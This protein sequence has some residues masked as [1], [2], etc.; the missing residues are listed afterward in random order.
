M[1]GKSIKR[2]LAISLISISM[3]AIGGCAASEPAKGS[4]TAST[5]ATTS[6][7]NNST[8]VL[9][10]EKPPTDHDVSPVEPTKVFD[11]LYYLGS[12]NVGAWV[13]NTSEGIILID[14]MNN[15]EDAENIIVPGIKKLG[16]DPANI[17]YVLVT[18]GHGD[19]YGGAKYIQD[20]FGATVLMSSIDWDFMVKNYK[21]SIAAKAEAEA[22]GKDTSK[23]R[24][25][26]AIPTS[27]TNITDDEKLTLGDTTITV[28]Y[29]P[30]HTPGCVSLIIPVTDN[31]K[32]HT[33]SIWGG[34]GLP[35][36]LEDNK[37]YESSIDYF[38]KFTDAAQVD[39]EISAHPF[40]DNAVE[41]MD[42]LGKRK[43]GDQNPFVIGQEGY[44]AYMAKMKEYATNNINKLTK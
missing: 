3:F 33:V 11:N 13:V 1:L 26:V 42:T 18:H 24:T 9:P 16:F 28:V 6:T 39:G 22:S 29:T 23:L 38:N 7:A 25:P 44:K 19:H 12:K 27:Y 10:A 43:T 37:K 8:T 40:I 41:R 30:G 4:D 20:N 2:L 21:D 35:Q 36:S 31:G 15:S 14:A 34:T 32:K 17:K 5:S